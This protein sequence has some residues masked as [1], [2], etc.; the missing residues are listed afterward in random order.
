[1]WT[2]LRYILFYY[3]HQALQDIAN[4][5]HFNIKKM[6][7]HILIIFLQT[8][9]LFCVLDTWTYL[10]LYTCHLNVQFYI[11]IPGHLWAK[12]VQ[13]LF[14]ITLAKVR[15]VKGWRSKHWHY[16]DNTHFFLSHFVFFQTIH[17][18]GDNKQWLWE[19]LAT[20]FLN[21]P[22]L[23]KKSLSIILDNKRKNSFSLL[24]LQR[25]NNKAGYFLFV[26][27]FMPRKIFTSPKENI[28]SLMKVY[29]PS[30]FHTYDF[31][32]NFTNVR[33]A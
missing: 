2:I 21:C 9:F 3:F 8:N 26:C 1:M 17:S 6:C 27:K 30:S 13:I 4:L 14:F 23:C 25:Q 18:S 24:K 29:F 15:R 22:Q 12:I 19:K 32:F 28:H 10:W 33:R 11:E 16:Q 7:I 5:M 31:F 20:L